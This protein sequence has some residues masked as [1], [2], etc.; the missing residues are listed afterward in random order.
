MLCYVAKKKKKNY[1]GKAVWLLLKI[2]FE[3]AMLEITWE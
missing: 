2:N 3:N 1:F